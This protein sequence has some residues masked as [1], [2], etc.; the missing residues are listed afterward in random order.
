MKRWSRKDTLVVVCGVTSLILLTLCINFYV[1][2]LNAY[3][4]VK[5]SKLG[6]TPLDLSL[7]E[8]LIFF[9]SGIL[10][11]LGRGGI[12]LYSVSTALRSHIAKFLYEEDTPEPSEVFQTDVWKPI[13]FVRAGLAFIISG[14]ILVRLYFLTLAH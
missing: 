11:L 10:F 7:V 5:M 1:L 6:W 12:N 8:G 3:L 9:C 13:P 4:R 14:V 2:P